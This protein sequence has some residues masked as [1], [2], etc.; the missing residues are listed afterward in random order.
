[1]LVF[2]GKSSPISNLKNT[3]STYP[4]GCFMVNKGPN[5]PNLQFLFSNQSILV[6]N[7]SR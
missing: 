1:V 2:T 6:I 7:S 4:E 3:I 5:Q